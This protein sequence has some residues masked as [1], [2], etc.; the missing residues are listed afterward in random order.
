MVFFENLVFHNKISLSFIT[1]SFHKTNC[2][3]LVEGQI[4][5]AH[6]YERK[7]QLPHETS[8]KKSLEL[9]PS[10]AHSCELQ[11]NTTSRRAL[12]MLGFDGFKS[13]HNCNSLEIPIDE[14]PSKV[15]PNLWVL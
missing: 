11:V 4:W 7:L 13:Q 14:H 8:V 2:G 12:Y 6:G 1:H 15:H 10:H 3:E 9:L 5:H